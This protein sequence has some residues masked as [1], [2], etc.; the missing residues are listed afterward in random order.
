M[1][2]SWD[3]VVSTVAVLP[4]NE[5]CQHLWRR[6]PVQT[7][8]HTATCFF[9]LGSSHAATAASN[10]YLEG[11]W[12]YTRTSW[13]VN[14]GGMIQVEPVS[15]GQM[16]LLSLV[17]SLCGSICQ[18]PH[19]TPSTPSL[20]NDTQPMLSLPDQMPTSLLCPV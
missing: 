11:K 20:D 12:T 15:V 9:S 10:C 2:G 14:P 1:P 18:L 4:R 7:T 8:G 17:P 3:I 16:S 19:P 6:L 13:K 5:K